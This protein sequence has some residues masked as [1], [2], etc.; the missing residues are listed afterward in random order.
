MSSVK[1]KNFYPD[2]GATSATEVNANYNAFVGSL[3]SGD[4]NNEN[5]RTEGIDLR[6]LGQR[7]IHKFIGQLNNG[8]FLSLGAVPSS[9]ARYNSYSVDV[10]QPKE[11]PLNHDNTGTSNTTVGKGTKLRVN[12]T[13]GAD[14]DGGEV[15]HVSWNVNMFTNF[16]HTPLNQLVTGLIDTTPKDS[17]TGA[18]YPYGSG[19]GEWCWLVYPKFNVTSSALNDADFQ[20]AEQAGLDTGPYLDPSA[21]TGINSIGNNHRTFD[22]FNW[23]HVMVMPELF[24]SAGNVSTSPY[25]AINSSS[26]IGGAA[27]SS[28]GGPQMFNGS[29]TFKVKDNV[30]N[31]L[32]LYGIQLYISGYW[33]M[34]GNT[35]GTGN[36]MNN[37]MFLEYEICDPS[38]TNTDGD[39]IPLYGVEG[40]VGIERIQTH[41]VIYHKAGG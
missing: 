14:F 16:A 34:H 2:N 9:D 39:P 26:T 36:P 25:L 28:L 31:S 30:S 35:T 29:F 20:T 41:F 10:N 3:G 6:N 5:V 22:A 12:G 13:A 33:R 24:A 38:R 15:I 1:P 27:A 40:A 37:G 8:Y 21:I 4:I 17:A 19:I 7:P 32:R 18:T 11:K 23:D